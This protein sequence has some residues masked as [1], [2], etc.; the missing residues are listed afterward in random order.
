MRSIYLFLHTILL[1]TYIATLWRIIKASPGLTPLVGWW[2]G[3]GQFL[4]A[5]LS[6]MVFLGGYQL[7]ERYQVDFY[8]REMNFRDEKFFLPYLVIWVSFLLASFCVNFF[9]P[10][11]QSS[12]RAKPTLARN[13]L[14]YI[15]LLTMAFS[16]LDWLISIKLAG[17]L[18]VFLL[19][20]W[21]ERAESLT[22]QFGDSFVLLSHL[23][24]ANQ[25]IFTI[26]AS[27][28][29]TFPLQGRKI[30]KWLLVLTLIFLLLGM[31]MSGNRIYVAIYLIAFLVSGLFY[32]RRRVIVGFLVA[33][34]F[35]ALIFSIWA[36]VRHDLTKISDSVG[37]YFETG[38]ESRVVSSA[39]DAAEGID[40]LLLLHMVRDFGSRY[41][42]MYGVS[43]TRSLLSFIPRALYP[44]KPKTF[45]GYLASLYLPNDLTSLNATALGEMYANFGPFTLLAFPFFTLSVIGL[46][47]WCE[48]RQFQHALVP[49]ILFAV[50][51]WTARTTF[52][53]SFV[54]F[55]I[56]FGLMSVFRMEKGLCFDKA[57]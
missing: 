14:E 27:L 46:T 10:S 21:Y 37:G 11:I 56:A 13:Q 45:S 7:P 23:S 51:F 53:D 39:F 32:S 54:L 24:S 1:I 2:A 30:R 29:S 8:W 25:L 12:E 44:E 26:A 40:T 50:M 57:S 47:K 17:G 9:L 5:P 43:Y 6:L 3:L 41:E 22:T 48:S 20:H 34:P 52:E 4:I 38:D 42:Y 19:S 18:E 33:A 28:Y 35:L 16:V 15:L 36:S 31:V 49:A 55:V